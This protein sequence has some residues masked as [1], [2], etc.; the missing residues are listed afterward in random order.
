MK[1]IVDYD[2][3]TSQYSS[4]VIKNVKEKIKDGWEPFGSLSTGR[5]INNIGN[6]NKTSEIVYSQSIVKY[7]YS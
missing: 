7:V 5:I 1:N 3:I 2:I 4:K 6:G